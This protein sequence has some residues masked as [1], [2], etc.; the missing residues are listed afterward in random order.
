M[1]ATSLI[2][3]KSFLKYEMFAKWQQTTVNMQMSHSSRHFRF[4]KV[5]SAKHFRRT[6]NIHLEWVKPVT[7]SSEINTL[8]VWLGFSQFRINFDNCRVFPS[9]LFAPPPVQSV[10]LSGATGR[11][12]LRSHQR[13]RDN[14]RSN[15]RCLKPFSVSTDKLASL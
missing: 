14:T 7:A 5:I 10:R 4:C 11:D 2:N 1:K 3:L 15:C 8:C 13:L 6:D 12:A 9:F